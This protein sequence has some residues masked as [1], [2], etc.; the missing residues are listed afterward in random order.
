MEL[1]DKIDRVKYNGAT[2]TNILR[3]TKP[4]SNIINRIDVFYPYVIKEGERAD[5]IAYDYYGDSSYTWLIYISN[6]IYD[7]YYQ[8]PLT[9]SQLF[10]FLNQKYGDF[11][12]TQIDIHHYFNDTYQYSVSPTTFDN[13]TV[14]QRFEWY[15]VTTFDYEFQLN[16]DK[17]NIKLISNKYLSQINEQVSTL[18]GSNT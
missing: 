7:P 5:T 10:D 3:R 17:R 9:S 12:Q 18:F 14:E 13:W 16:E 2:L 6:N 11:Y 8:W 15:P 1:F 4:I